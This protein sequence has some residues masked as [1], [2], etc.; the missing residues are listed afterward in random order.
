MLAVRL[1]ASMGLTREQVRE[2]LP[3]AWRPEVVVEHNHSTRAILRRRLCPACD[4]HHARQDARR[5]SGIPNVAAEI[6][7]WRRSP[8]TPEQVD[9]EVLWGRRDQ[10]N[11]GKCRGCGCG[12]LTLLGRWACSARLCSRNLRS[13]LPHAAQAETSLA[14]TYWLFLSTF[15]WP[16]SLE[17][18]SCGAPVVA[19]CWTKP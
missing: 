10:Q 9:G 1:V 14:I 7:D 19:G 5:L 12:P 16:G 8:A 11:R 3:P 13:L 2:A 6:F 17:R 15:T 18:P 4:E